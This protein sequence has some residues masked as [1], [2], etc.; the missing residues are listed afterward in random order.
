MGYFAEQ[1]AE[2]IFTSLTASRW[3][4]L[5]RAVEPLVLAVADGASVPVTSTLWPTWAA[6]LFEGSSSV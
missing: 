5:A 6:S 2:I 3:P 1:S 4:A